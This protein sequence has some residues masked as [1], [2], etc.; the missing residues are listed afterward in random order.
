M[1]LAPPM[2]HPELGFTDPAQFEAIAAGFGD[3]GAVAG[4]SQGGDRASLRLHPD[5]EQLIADAAAACD[6]VVV[7]VMAGSA[8]VMPWLDVRARRAHGVVSGIRGRPRRG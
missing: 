5:D 6:Q 2:D 1:E 4:L 3:G 7:A 8:V